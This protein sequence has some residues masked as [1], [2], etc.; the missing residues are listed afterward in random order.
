MVVLEIL[1]EN[2]SDGVIVLLFWYLFLGVFGM[3]VYKM[4][5]MFDFMIG[6]RNECYF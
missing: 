5:N 3:F 6:Y 4:V 1:V 2:L